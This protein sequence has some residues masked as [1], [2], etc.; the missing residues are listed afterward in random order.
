MKRRDIL[1]TVG[2]AIAG[3]ALLPLQSFSNNENDRRKKENLIYR[4]KEN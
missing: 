4:K 3:N 2:L 1:K